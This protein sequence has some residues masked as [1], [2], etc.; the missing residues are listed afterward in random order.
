MISKKISCSLVAFATIAIANWAYQQSNKEEIVLSELAME[1]VEAL[2]N[3][4]NSGSTITGEC[5]SSVVIV[6]E[7]KVVCPKCGTE[8]YPETRVPQ[9]VPRSVS[10]KCGQC[11]NSD[12]SKYN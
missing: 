11:G 12:W 6:T 5:S 9:A 2:A 3:N 4:E 10:G 7:C 8:W 1:N